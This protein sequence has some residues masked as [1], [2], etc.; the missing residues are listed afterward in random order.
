MLFVDIAFVKPVTSRPATG[1]LYLVGRALRPD[2]ND[3][4]RY[5]IV[6]M[7][8]AKVEVIA[9]LNCQKSGTSESLI[10][11]E[12]IFSCTSSAMGQ[13]FLSYCRAVNDSLIKYQVSSMLL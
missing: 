6:N 9:E 11:P 1:E 2:L 4:H 7:L 3:E 12:S 8:W 10:A 5:N 13:M